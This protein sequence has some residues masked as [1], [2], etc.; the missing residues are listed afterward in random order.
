MSDNEQRH[1]F[2]DDLAEDVTLVSTVLRRPVRGADLVRAVVRAGAAQYLT[3]TPKGLRTVE[4]RTYFEY[5]VTLA[6]GL[7]S[8]GLVSIRRD[9]AGAVTH[10]HIAFSPLGSVLAIAAGLR[11]AL[12]AELASDLFL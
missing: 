11:D 12:A 6:G 2:L 5:E 8:D 4:D 9:T 1:P 3:Q 7:A 10:L